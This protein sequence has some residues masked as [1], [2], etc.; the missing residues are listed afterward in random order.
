MQYNI[1]FDELIGCYGTKYH[2]Y[3]KNNLKFSLGEPSREIYIDFIWKMRSP[4][5]YVGLHQTCFTLSSE[6]IKVIKPRMVN[7]SFPQHTI[8]ILFLPSMHLE[9][10]RS[11]PTWA[12]WNCSSSPPFT[13][14]IVFESCELNESILWEFYSL[15]KSVRLRLEWLWLNV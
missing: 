13:R 10:I 14:Y 3:K 1:L 7:A 6:H 15:N 12:S 2:Q 11:E 9:V 4:S 5:W 8:T